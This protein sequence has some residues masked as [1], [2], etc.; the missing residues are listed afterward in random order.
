MIEEQK[1]PLRKTLVRRSFSLKKLITAKQKY[2]SEIDSYYK[3]IEQYVE[4][5]FFIMYQPSDGF[6]IVHSENSHNAP[7]SICVG[8]IEDKGKL[9][10]E[11]YLTECI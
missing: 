5:D 2:E 9:S 10:Y 1:P 6:V 8:I 7:L 3:K 11:D 4:F